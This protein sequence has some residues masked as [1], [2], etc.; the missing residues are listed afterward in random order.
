MGA[1]AH[2]CFPEGDRVCSALPSP[3]ARLPLQPPLILLSGP[4][5]PPLGSHLSAH[6]LFVVSSLHSLTGHGPSYLSKGLNLGDFLPRGKRF[7]G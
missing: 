6:T 3:H 1:V 5:E 4:S 7:L 2:S